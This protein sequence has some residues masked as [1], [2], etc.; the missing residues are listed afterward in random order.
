M[1]VKC[2]QLELSGSGLRRGVGEEPGNAESQRLLAAV[3]QDGRLQL[4]DRGEH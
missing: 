4:L 1:D 2:K 3:R